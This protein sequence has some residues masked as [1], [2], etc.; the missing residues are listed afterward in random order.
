MRFERNGQKKDFSIGRMCRKTMRTVF[1]CCVLALPTQGMPVRAQEAENGEEEGLLQTEVVIVLPGEDDSSADSEDDAGEV[2]I[3]I[4]ADAAQDT[5]EEIVIGADDTGNTDIA[6]EDHST[7]DENGAS[8]ADAGTDTDSAGEAPRIS[9]ETLDQS[10]YSED[11]SQWIVYAE[12]DSVSVDGDGCEALA[13]AVCEWNEEQTE[14][15]WSFCAELAESAGEDALYEDWGSDSYYYNAWREAELTRVD[16]SVLSLVIWEYAYTGGAHGNYG[17]TSVTFDVASGEILQLTELLEDAEGFCDSAEAYIVEALE[18]EYGDE[19]FGGYEE[20]VAAMWDTE[21]TWYLD[22]EGITFVFDPYELGPYS[23]GAASVTCPYE[24]VAAY[25]KTAYSGINGTGLGRFSANTD[26][27]TAAGTLRLSVE[28]DPEYSMLQISL[29]L[30]GETACA[31]EFGSFG[32]AYLLVLSNGRSFVLFDADYMSDDYVT[33]LY[34]ITD[35]SITLRSRLEGVSLQEGTV[36]T[37]V[38]TLRVHLDVLGTY[39]AY[40]DYVIGEDGTLMQTEDVFEIRTDGYSFRILTVIRELP[41]TMDDGQAATLPVGTRIRI[42]GSDDAGTAYFRDE[43]SGE[44]GSISYERGSGDDTWTL[45]IDGVS[46]Y[47]YFE[48]IPYAG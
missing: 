47:E 8:G 25:M 2:E 48:M 34:E 38:L 10:W 27:E 46:E 19:L 22:A 37:E 31:D 21:L 30:N 12:C 13:E 14:S 6:A 39:S 32:D 36:G 24:I 23:M 20:T 11:G 5:E 41:V 15:F 1:L 4:G 45:Y 16:E 40:M 17:Y 28:E 44:K 7:D 26:V 42:T 29:Q 9:I 35:G 18:T 43:D 3:V 33:F